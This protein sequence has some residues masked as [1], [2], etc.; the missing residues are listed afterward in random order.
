ML[1]QAQKTLAEL[2][3]ATEFIARHIGIDEA[4]EA[5]MLQVV[6]SASRKELIAGIVPRS[7]ARIARF[8]VNSSTAR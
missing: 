2:E 6:G 5:L 8:E 4:D 3:N 7:I 1:M